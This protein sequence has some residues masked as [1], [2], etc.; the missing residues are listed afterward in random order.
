LVALSEQSTYNERTMERLCL[1][2]S[3]LSHF[4]SEIIR[5]ML[6][7][8]GNVAVYMQPNIVG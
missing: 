6:K 2:D 1:F 8:F 7:V 3:Q 4:I 5:L